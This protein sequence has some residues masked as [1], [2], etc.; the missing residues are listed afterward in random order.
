MSAAIFLFIGLDATYRAK[1][2]QAWPSHAEGLMGIVDCCD[3]HGATVEAFLKA[4]TSDDYPGV[5]DYEVTVEMGGWLYDNLGATD[6]AFKAE[7][8][9]LVAKWREAAHK[10]PQSAE[11]PSHPLTMTLSEIRAMFVEGERWAYTNSRF[12]ECDGVQKLTKQRSRDLIWRADGNK[13]NFM[14]FPA[15]SAILEANDG[16]LKYIVSGDETHVI[17]WRRLSSQP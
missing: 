9:S 5:F 8:E 4:D 17:T 3:R 13:K 14:D 6:E 1:T 2:G 12:P 11:A 16:Y 7:L 15:K 10:A